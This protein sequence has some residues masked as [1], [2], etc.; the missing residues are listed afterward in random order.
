[1]SGAQAEMGEDPP[2]RIA[3]LRALQ[4]GDLLC[5][6]PALRALRAAAPQARIT[7]IGLPWACSFVERY[8]AYLDD[9]MVLPGVPGLPE[10]PVQ[11]ELMPAF[12]AAA[13]QREFDLAIQL[14]GSGLRTNPLL[15]RLGA[16]RNAGFYMPGHACPD[17]SRFLPWS[18]REQEVLRALR[19]ME[20]LGV[21]PQGNALEFPLHETDYRA[22]QDCDATLPAPGTYACLHPGAR[23]ASRRWPPQ[24]FAETADRLARLGL[25]IVL[26]GSADEAGL[27]QAVAHAMRAPAL[28]LAGK[29]SIGALA[30]LLSQARLAICNDTGISH[31]AVA[32]GTPSVVICSGADPQRWAPLD[33]HRHRTLAHPV[34]CRPCM[35]AACPIGHPCAL[36]IEVD[37]VMREA[38]DILEGLDWPA[39]G[40]EAML[41]IAASAERR[42]Q[43]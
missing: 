4:L 5:A 19:L 27:T 23:M 17:R 18:E 11:I 28:D 36:G 12:V 40:L 32:V 13:R 43:P 25:R 6:V 15:M 16:K 21:T 26:T 1:M 9:F 37:A 31:V 10:Q 30:A 14:H 22:L 35:H 8:R 3:V 33:H 38:R 29:T 41:P 34:A 42:L 20:L 7:L 24:R 39:S 2:R